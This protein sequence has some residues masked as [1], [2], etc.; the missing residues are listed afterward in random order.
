MKNSDND[1]FSSFFSHIYVEKKV[2]THPRAKKI[3]AEYPKAQ[4]IEIGH[5]KDV[6]CR[7]RQD[8]VLQHSSQ[9]LILAAKDKN[10]IY[11]GSPVC[12]SFGNDHFYYTSCMMNCI[13]DCAYCYLKGMYASANIVVF[14]NLEDF[15]EETRQ[16]LSKN[17]PVYLCV[18]Y[19][20]DLLA[21]EQVT[22]YAEAWNRFAA[23]H[24]QHFKIEI[25]TK[26]ANVHF[27]EKHRPLPNVIYAFTL[28]P[29]VIVERF[30]HG[31]PSFAAR[32]DCAARAAEAGFLVRLCFDP[33]IYVPG[34]QQY[35][36]EMLEQVFASLAAEKLVDVSVGSFRISQE[37]LKKMR[38][39][40]PDSAAAWFP[41]EMEDGYYHYPKALMKEMEQYLVQR[42]LEYL[43]A[44]KIFLWGQEA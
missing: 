28:S 8:Y 1:Y 25:R 34:W 21:L 30:E 24:T 27:F 29:Q 23:E 9:K 19:D 13:Y 37:Y 4:V 14:V 36:Q 20:T 18:S 10:L 26:C 5:Y 7:S 12:Q 31:T 32:A 16:M 35:Y 17:G 2:R 6:F 39:Q 11:Q 41:Y 33:M 3:L 22:G 40:Q 42:L 38:R 15:F 44:E 43:P